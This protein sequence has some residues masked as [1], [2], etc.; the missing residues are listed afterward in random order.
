MDE[1]DRV[2]EKIAKYLCDLDNPMMWD[3]VDHSF[4]EEKASKPCK[5]IYRNMASAILA[6]PEIQIKSDDQS[7]PLIEYTRCGRL[8]AEMKAEGMGMLIKDGWVRCLK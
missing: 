6:I 1:G 2:K 7:L 4:W 3:K 8:E 5:T